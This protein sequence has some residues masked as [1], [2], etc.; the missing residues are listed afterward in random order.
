MDSRQDEQERGITM[1]SSAISLLY[2]H[3][4]L[5]K[6]YLVNLIDSPGHVDFSSDVSTAVRLCDGALVVV[7]VI[8]GVAIQT[9]AV[10][11]QAWEERLR[12]CL[13]LNKIDRLIIE[14]QLDPIEAYEHLLKIV[15]RVN[16]IQMGFM[17]ASI[18]ARED[19]K[20]EASGA[21]LGGEARGVDELGDE[22]IDTQAWALEYDEDE[23]NAFLFAPEKG[24]VV[25]CS[26]ADSWAFRTI[27]FVPMVSQALGIANRRKVLRSLWG[28]FW[29]SA[30]QGKIIENKSTS[31]SVTTGEASRQHPPMFASFVLD[32]I[33]QVYGATVID[34]K[35]KK[36]EKMVTRLG[37][38]D[39]INKRDLA[40]GGRAA[41]R[42]TMHTW[43]PVTRAVLSMVVRCVPD[44]I[45]AQQRRAEI[46]WPHVPTESAEMAE[47]LAKTETS[48]KDCDPNGPLVVFVSKIFAVERREVTPQT[49]ALLE[50]LR[51]KQL[52][53]QGSHDGDEVPIEGFEHNADADGEA[54]ES[55]LFF[56]FARVFSGT[57]RPGVPV[58]VL[59]PKYVPGQ[60]ERHHALVPSGVIPL[61]MMN[62]ELVPLDA[63]P[64][65][66]ILALAGLDRDVLKTA[67]VTDSVKCCSL[68]KM[69]SQSAPVLRVSLEPNNPLEWPKLTH[70]L[71]LLNRADAVAEVRIQ[72]NGEHILG[73]IGELH[74]ERCVKDLQDRFARIELKVSKPIAIFR[75]TVVTAA[76][77]SPPSPENQGFSPFDLREEEAKYTADMQAYSAAL[78]GESMGQ[79]DQ[80]G[81]ADS[82]DPNE[83]KL[84]LSRPTP[85]AKRVLPGG[86]V[87]AC[88]PGNAVVTTLRLIPLPKPIRKVL[89]EVRDDLIELFENEH[90]GDD[91]DD[92]DDVEDDGNLKTSASRSSTSRRSS[93]ANQRRSSRKATNRS[94]AEIERERRMEE[95]RRRIYEKLEEAFGEAGEDWNMQRLWSLGPRGVGPN[96]LLN[97]I[98]AGQ[99]LSSHRLHRLLSKP[100]AQDAIAE[101]DGENEEEEVEEGDEAPSKL[102]EEV[103]G[104][105]IAG[106]QLACRAGPVCEEPL[107]GTCVVIEQ[108][109]LKDDTAEEHAALKKNMA[110]QG[111]VMSGVRDAIRRSVMVHAEQHKHG[112][113]TGCEVRLV[114]GFFKCMLQCH[115]EMQAGDQLGRMYGVLSSRRAKI[116]SE[117]MWEGTSIFTIE[118]LVPIVESFRLGDDLRRQTSGAASTP[119]LL[120][121]HWQ[122]IPDNP[123]FRATTEDE[124]EEFGER[125]YEESYQAHNRAYKYIQ[126]IRKRKGLSTSEKVVVAAEKQ[127]TL[128]KK[129]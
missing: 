40:K 32:A 7:D 72:P 38:L 45:R 82:V 64:A 88:T 95:R 94:A 81:G 31:A 123:F 90:D 42:T 21:A 44:P 114:E 9:H 85:F 97:G 100:G 129:K 26:A 91:D 39:K 20:D 56:A 117:D 79:T 46:L 110:I 36:L 78:S 2:K 89:E 124:L 55:E 37:I 13:V 29:Y 16:A 3:E 35:P 22:K 84:K 10:L 121:S 73:C 120:F 75:E 8:E 17:N 96:V 104:G 47:A 70:G 50:N 86:R 87:L 122:I 15:E 116:V 34:S 54:Q 115:V 113:E 77:S 63:V 12:P 43:L 51:K 18:M 109:T 74:L 119:Q 125:G 80:D 30:K 108:V 71:K 27:D 93:M 118:A 61:L 53:T 58:H 48:I 105:V 76:E 24:N 112:V 67:T 57:V 127:R 25:F 83:I 102:L 60:P 52:A 33:W 128:A 111:Q 62:T 69:P 126:E 99:P 98:E 14:R 103:A 68:T 92:E 23:E 65:G 6:N 106:F 66:N 101:G 28:N 5:N 59:G 1:K 4:R 41:L 11:R 49:A 107:W 19:E